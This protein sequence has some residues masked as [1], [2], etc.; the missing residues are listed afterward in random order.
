MARVFISHSGRNSS[1]A[2]EVHRWLVDSGHDA[3]LDQDLSDGLLV[4]EEWQQRLHERL[5]WADAVLC[6]LT[7]A[8]L[9]SVWC[10]A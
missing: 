1:I 2:D 6:V 7:T 5:R 8:Y 3:F 9:G 4:G 10:T